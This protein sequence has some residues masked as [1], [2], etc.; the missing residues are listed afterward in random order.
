M[1]NSLLLLSKARKELASAW[2]W[3]ED[4]QPGLGDRFVKVIF[5]K[6]A[7]IEQTPERYP[8]R[9]KQYREAVVPVFPYLIIYH[10]SKSEKTIVVASI[11]HTKRNP[12]K[13]IKK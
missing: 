2:G 1:S 11:F 7:Q 8:K 12:A 6:L 5:D 4:R 10:F 13:K 9:I 3:Y